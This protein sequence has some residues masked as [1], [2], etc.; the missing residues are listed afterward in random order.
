[1]RILLISVNREASPYPVAPLGLAYVAGAA[2]QDGHTVSLVDLC[3]STDPGATIAAAVAQA[4]PD[5]IGISIRNIDNLTFPASASYL[6]EIAS[7]VASIRAVSATP[8]VAGGPGFSIFP[9]RLLAFFDLDYGVVGEGEEIFRLLAADL[10]AGRPV[11]RL[12][13]LLRRGDPP[14]AATPAPPGPNGH[15]VPA[16]DLLDNRAYLERGGMANLQTKR[17][18]PFACAYCTYPHISGTRVRLRP[19]G[20]VAE[21]LAGM[22]AHGLD[23]IFF[24]D[25]VFNWPPEHALAVCDAIQA[26]G[27]RLRWTCFAS[28]AGMSPTLA[29]AMKRAGCRGVEFGADSAS[30]SM[31]RA[32]AKPF[33]QEELRAAAA[34]CRAV[35]L[36]AAYYLIFGGPGETAE[37]IAETA[38]VLDELEPHAVLAFLG[39]RVYPGTPLHR[40]ALQDGVVEPTDDLLAPRFYISP[41]LGAE[42]LQALL[43][44]HA[45]RRPAWVVPGLGI[46]FDPTLLAALRRSGR[47]G[48]LWDLLPRGS[49]GC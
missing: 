36:P 47:R 31:L 29:S 6:A 17:G 33:P 1:M 28:P 34:A 15:R 32:L 44:R 4:R 43:Q 11:G 24:V 46:R 48:P 14:G 8:L 23:E 40:V 37:T 26:R 42:G 18:C 41:L 35:D 9:E 20:E 45:E 10:E 3:F 30:P 49:A 22:T 27:L 7:A 13:G 5:L 25:D 19:P 38:A 12:A 2:C 39:I 21:E 16:R